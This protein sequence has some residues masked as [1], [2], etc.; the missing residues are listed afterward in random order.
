MKTAVILFNLGGPDALDSV[1][2]FLKNLFNDPAILG[3]PGF[4]RRALAHFIANKR[5]E[6]AKHIYA[7]LGGKSPL[8]ENTQSQADALENVLNMNGSRGLGG[9][10][11]QTESEPLNPSAPQPPTYK[12]FVAMRYWHPLSDETARAVLA[13]QPDKIV[14]LPL[15]PQFSTTTTASSFKA[16]DDA[17]KA[18]YTKN[19]PPIARIGCYPTLN[20]FID[21]GADLLAPVYRQVQANA[22]AKGFNKPPRILFSAHGLPQKVIQ[23]GDPYQW[24]CEQT[25]EAIVRAL[26][27][28]GLGEISAETTGAVAVAPEQDEGAEQSRNL[29]LNTYQSR[30]GPLKW[31]QPYTD[32]E[33][34]RAGR[35][36]VPLVICPIAFV[37][38]HSETLYELDQQYV[39][40]ARESGVPAYGRVPTVSTHS[41]FIGGLADLV[42]ES[43]T[44]RPRICPTACSKCGCGG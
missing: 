15:Y 19:L 25:A 17:L 34:K 41:A 37:S 11:A 36:G 4:V 21:A 26:G 6:E 12:C 35:E 13:W 28:K 43:A 2:P 3:V 23:A 18:L 44:P 39:A 5:E 30:V 14:Y 31:T 22:R 16:F 38:E 33:I 9:L 20:G 7:A 10:G 40:L 27:A 42:R 24:Q 8:L 32:E 29:Y 1:K